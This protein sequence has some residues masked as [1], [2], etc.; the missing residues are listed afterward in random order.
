[1][2]GSAWCSVEGPALLAL[3]FRRSC[4]LVKMMSGRTVSFH[5]VVA[6]TF[7]GNSS[8]S[9]TTVQAQVKDRKEEMSPVVCVFKRRERGSAE[10]GQELRQ[11]PN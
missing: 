10:L 11:K 7:S 5:S 2:S 4:H 8:S 1:M 9:P 3:Q 6:L